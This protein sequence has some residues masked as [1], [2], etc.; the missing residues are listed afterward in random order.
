MSQNDRTPTYL[1]ATV[2]VR[3]QPQDCFFTLDCGVN[4]CPGLAIA[5]IILPLAVHA[6][7]YAL[8]WDITG[9]TY[10]VA[11][12]KVRYRGD[13]YKFDFDRYQKFNWDKW[14]QFPAL[15]ITEES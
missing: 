14:Q 5:D 2:T 12:H 8:V 4:W 13:I 11:K 1:S 15:R 6:N 9:T 10:W 7:Q 3:S